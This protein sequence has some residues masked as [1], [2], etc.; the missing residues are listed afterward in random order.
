MS[1][2]ES[3]MPSISS[4]V[5]RP[6]VSVSS[7]LAAAYVCTL[8]LIF[9][10]ATS[11]RMWHWFVVPVWFCGLV[12]GTDTIDWLRGKTDVFDAFGLV[13][14]LGFHFF[15]AAPLLHPYLDWWMLYVAPPP[16]WRDWLGWM[17]LLNLVGLFVYRAVRNTASK[18]LAVRPEQGGWT[19]HRERFG[20][21]LTAAMIVSGLL[22]IW[23][24]ASYGGIAGYIDSFS[25]SLSLGQRAFMG[26]GY[27]FVLSEV[28]PL[29][30]IMG[31]AV[32]AQDKPGLQ[33][34]PII[35]FVLA[36]FM[37]LVL[38]FGGLRGSRANTIWSL[39][40][41]FGVIHF[42][43]RPIPKK[44]LPIGIAFFLLFMYIYGFY[45]S[46]GVEV[47]MLTE[48]PHAQA[49]LEARTQRTFSGLLLGDLGRSDVQALLLERMMTPGNNLSYAW[50]RTYVGA[51]SLA[52]PSSL[53]PQR[54][55]GKLKEGTDALFGR[56]TYESSGFAASNQYGFAGEAMLNFGP[57]AAPLAFVVLGLLTAWV[58]DLTRRWRQN[59][60]RLLILPLLI[61]LSFLVL[62]YDFDNVLFFLLK[63]FSIPF[64]IV[65]LGSDR[66][67]NGMRAQ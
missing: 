6:K 61:N 29:L 49:Q 11:D 30:A 50:G 60:A 62:I 58:N 37:L 26:Q 46:I 39:F 4:P 47:I 54:I 31:F 42:L 45:K 25:S 22:Q 12:I 16:E 63:Y 35:G 1:L 20:I 41:A 9:M 7:S 23:V 24:Y 64:L 2:A 57:F 34:W 51:I 40:A 28:F 48:T 56:G 32:Y 19:L 14:V 66:K 52:V 15:F 17:A 36:G 53:W 67:P 13:G 55:P 18:K 8:I 27:L 43:V 33:R 3:A 10:L 5:A 38:L 59:D 44:I 65:W 21:W